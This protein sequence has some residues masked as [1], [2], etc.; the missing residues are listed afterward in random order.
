MFTTKH[1]RRACPHIKRAF[2]CPVR[3]ISFGDP[4]APDHCK[5]VL[6]QHIISTVDCHPIRMTLP[7]LTK[8][9]F[10]KL[11]CNGCHL[12]PHPDMRRKLTN[13]ENNCQSQPHFGVHP[14]RE[15]CPLNHQANKR[16]MKKEWNPDQ[17][18][19]SNTHE[20]CHNS[21]LENQN[22]R[23]PHNSSHKPKNCENSDPKSPSTSDL[24]K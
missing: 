24:K 9:I 7:K 11:L 2:K 5:S 13:H 18:A 6:L 19:G 12:V 15:P 17:D 1:I 8:R 14:C 22:H 4:P 16:Q 3:E 10:F 21:G 20:E 23:F